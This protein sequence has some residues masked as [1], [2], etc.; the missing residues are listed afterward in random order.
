SLLPQKKYCD[1]TGLEAPYMDPKTRLR[2]HSADV[3]Q[4]IKT[5][6]DFSVQGYLGLRN[7]AVDLK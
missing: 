2:Y 3:Y 5:L 6:P 4:F 7:A 1:V